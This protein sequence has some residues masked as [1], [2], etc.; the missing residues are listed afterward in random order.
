MFHTSAQCA[1]EDFVTQRVISKGRMVQG[2]G[3]PGGEF[4][5]M[6]NLKVEKGVSNLIEDPWHVTDRNLELCFVEMSTKNCA[7]SMTLGVLE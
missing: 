5:E 6:L 4:P 1:C 7:S 3:L 2:S